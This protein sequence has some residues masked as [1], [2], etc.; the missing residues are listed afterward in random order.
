MNGN[1]VASLLA[2]AIVV[3][4]LA[5]R[6]AL[7]TLRTPG[8][9]LTERLSGFEDDDLG[10]DEAAHAERSSF[11][12]RILHP[13]LHATGEWT[14]RH[15]GSARLRTLERQLERAGRPLGMDAGAFVALQVTLLAIAIPIGLIP[16]FVLHLQGLMAIAVPGGALVLACLGPRLVITSEARGRLNQ[17][18]SQLPE[19][20]DLLV[21]CLD[22]GLTFELGLRR[23]VDHYRTPL[24]REF[25]L[26]LGQISLGRPM[27]EAFAEMAHRTELRDIMD[28]SRA[29][30][31]AEPLGVGVARILRLQ[32]EE[33][34][35]KA[36]QRA[37]EQGA[38]APLKMMFPMACC[39]FPTLFIA[40]LGP[41]IIEALS[42][43]G[44]H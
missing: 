38:R 42:V 7:V 28:L 41:G 6:R 19:V 13:L 44:H 24:G 31:Q 23:V 16:L 18:R 43:L 15:T 36:R 39:I 37:M 11:R 25:D 17:M 32:S 3:I 40:I 21:T 34:R 12:D 10:L 33:L 14:A 20:I 4:A 8:N 29:I 22:A 35:R 1:N 27:A 26:A 30:A 9:A 2:I 5:G